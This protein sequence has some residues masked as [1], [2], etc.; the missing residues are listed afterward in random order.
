LSSVLNNKATANEYTEANTINSGPCVAV[1]VF[2]YNEP[3]YLQLKESSSNQ[4]GQA[5]WTPEIY[6]PPQQKT[7][8]RRGIFA[9]RARSAVEGKAAQVTLILVG[10]R[11][12]PESFFLS[13]ILRRLGG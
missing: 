2:V 8:F 13:E 7:F 1:E 12:H 4:D 11:E 9:A 6:L 5:V 3:I 10:E